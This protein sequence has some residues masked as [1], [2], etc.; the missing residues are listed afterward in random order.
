MIEAVTDV[1]L[2]DLDVAMSRVCKRDFSEDPLK[3]IPKL[4]GF[5][6]G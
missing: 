6:G 2:V 1:R 5:Q 3:C 4:H